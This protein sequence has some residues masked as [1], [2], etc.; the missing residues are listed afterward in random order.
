MIMKKTILA[1]VA[2]FAFAIG[3]SAQEQQGEPKRPEG[4]FNKEE[5]VK[6]RVEGMVK[7]LGLDDAQ[8]TKLQKLFEKQASKKGFG[9]PPRKPEGAPKD[10][11][12]MK[13]PS[14]KD[15]QK[16]REEMEKERAE[17]N[18][19]LK[20]ILTSEQYTKYEE[21]EKQRSKRG[22]GR[23]GGRPEKR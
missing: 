21:L 12:G 23:R 14:E 1:I 17:F 5:M 18:A 22:G 13:R 4:K 15:M 10:T 3:V 2:L 6:H 7:E 11:V 8:K 9:M 20:K 16:M 19:E